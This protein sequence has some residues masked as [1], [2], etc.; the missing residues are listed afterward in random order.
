VKDRKKQIISA[1]HII[2]SGVLIAF[3]ANLLV[4]FK[5]KETLHLFIILAL[6][7]IVFSAIHLMSDRLHRSNIWKILGVI[8]LLV[9]S[10]LGP[11]LIYQVRPY[12]FYIT[13]MAIAVILLIA[14]SNSIISSMRTIGFVWKLTIF[15]CSFTLAYFSPWNYL[16]HIVM[17][18]STLV[19]GV[20]F[21]NVRNRIR[22]ALVIVFVLTAMGFWKYSKPLK[23]FEEQANYED[24]VLFSASTQFHKLVVTQWQDDYWVF[25]DKL[26]DIS[27][28]DDFLFYEPMVHSVFSIGEEIRDVL[29]VGGENGCLMKEVLKYKGIAQLDIISYDTLLRDIGK[30]E[31]FF[32][33][34][35]EGA[36]EQEKTN[37]IRKDLIGYLSE[38]DRSY[39]AIFI[40]LPDP[41]SIETNQYYTR[42]FYQLIK[43]M[44][45]EDGIM[46]TQAGSPY[47]ATAAFLSI[48]Q[49]I[50]GVGFHILPLHNQIL[51]L[52]EWGWYIA[53]TSLAG[54]EMKNRLDSISKH[55][56]ETEWFDNEAAKMISSFGKMPEAVVIPGINTLDSPLVYRYYLEGNWALN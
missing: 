25:K 48:G 54:E 14:V 43:N 40:D 52:G 20:F 23:Y 28:I 53:S 41:R 35:N 18:M 6:T 29:V 47:F 26:K 34:M 24:K 50:Q 13:G 55:R 3:L 17:G 4:Y 32:I 16:Q 49:T 1:L 12:T 2:L 15:L 10:W 22:I 38:A 7:V 9:I 8:L 56:V 51:T 30:N 11:Q 21:L 27:S 31:E 5:Q 45:D 39:D 44:L 33:K 42:E 37:I 19:A 36:Y 46:I